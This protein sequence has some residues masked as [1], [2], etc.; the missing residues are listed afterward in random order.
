MLTDARC[1]LHDA[2]AGHPE[3]PERLSFAMEAVSAVAPELTT[4][5][6]M[7]NSL[8]PIDPAR[9]ATVHTPAY[10]ER[11]LGLAGHN[12][13]LDSD[14]RISPNSIE[15][16][17]LAATAAVDSVGAVLG[18]EAEGAIC[19]TRPPGHHACPARAMGFCL[20]NNAAVAAASALSDHSCHRVMIFDPDVHHGNGTQE[21]FYARD[22]VLYVSLH[23]YP[24]YP[25]NSGAVEETGTGVGRG[26][27]INVPLPAGC[28]DSEYA[29][30]MEEVVL[31][32]VRAYH[33]DLV[34]VSAGFDAHVSDPL[35]DM[36]LTGSGLRDLTGR[37]YRLLDELAIPW[38]A[39]LEGGYAPSAVRDGVAALL[40]PGKP[41]PALLERAHDD[42]RAAV[43]A[44]HSAALLLR[45]G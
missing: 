11:M 27:T 4:A 30:A 5:V 45:A 22:D 37:L 1:S 23:Q 18:G 19:I 42:A 26:F 43:G 10:V 24:W 20:F 32:A 2:G 40:S 13:T 44:A 8:Q 36:R 16:A 25:W 35:A 9:L 12:K 17:R 7:V 33:P 28:G 15:A 6:R 31:L 38:T 41:E 21:I 39:V 3:R 29:L 14:T 34:I